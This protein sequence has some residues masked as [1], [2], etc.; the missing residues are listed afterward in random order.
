MKNPSGWVL[1]CQRVWTVENV[2]FWTRMNALSS[3]EKASKTRYKLKICYMG[4]E[5][6]VTV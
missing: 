5:Y 6:N 2:A 4:K 1:E 3:P